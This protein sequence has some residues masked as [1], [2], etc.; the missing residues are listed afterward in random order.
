MFYIRGRPVFAPGKVHSDWHA[1]AAPQLYGTKTIPEVKDI[2]LTFYPQ[3]KRK[4]DLTNKAES[5]MDLLVDCGVLTDDNW[6]VVPSLTLKFG[7]ADKENP[8]VEITIN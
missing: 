8:R 1:Q 4:S 5:V 7:G 6:F 3:S 2:T